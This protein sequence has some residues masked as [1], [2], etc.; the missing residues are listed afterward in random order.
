MSTP[1]AAALIS[2]AQLVPTATKL[3]L[4]R[5][6]GLSGVRRGVA[7]M[8]SFEP[9]GLRFDRVVAA[10][11]ASNG[12]GRTIAHPCRS[13]DPRVHSCGRPRPIVDDLHRGDEL[14]VA[15]VGAADGRPCRDHPGVAPPLVRTT[16]R[17]AH[18]TTHIPYH[19]SYHLSYHPPWYPLNVSCPR[20]THC[21]R[22]PPAVPPLV[23]PMLSLVPGGAGQG[24]D[25]LPRAY[26]Q[27]EG[28][29]G[30]GT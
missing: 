28:L 6:L 13:T 10:L 17:A 9:R 2:A 21:L 5:R 26:T 12:L 29:R 30:G 25:R 3:E 7:D 14:C 11:F 8:S 1:A 4:I 20:V 19:S 24:P 23:P 22:S 16:P 27:P 15:E 18:R